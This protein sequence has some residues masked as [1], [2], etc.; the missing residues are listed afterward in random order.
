MARLIACFAPNGADFA[1]G[2]QWH[3]RVGFAEEGRRPSPVQLSF[4]FAR[5][6]WQPQVLSLQLIFF[7]CLSPV[8]SIDLIEGKC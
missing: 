7:G 5:A 3:S 6:Y 8:H 1:E 2:L 4:N